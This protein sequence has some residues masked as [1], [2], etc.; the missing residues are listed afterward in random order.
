[1]DDLLELL[2][3]GMTPDEVLADYP[4]RERDDLLAALKYGAL[5]AS[6]SKIV[7]LLVSNR[8]VVPSDCGKARL[9]CARSSLR[10]SPVPRKISRPIAAPN[11]LRIADHG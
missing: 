8:T 4:D 3:S 10:G 2:A 7:P 5:T 9:V 6:R 11:R 1:M